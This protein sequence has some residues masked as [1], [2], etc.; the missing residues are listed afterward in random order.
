M[1]KQ[2][3]HARQ[4]RVSSAA[5]RGQASSVLQARQQ[6]PCRC[7]A[8]SASSLE[9]RLTPREQAKRRRRS[10]W[11]AIGEGRARGGHPKPPDSAARSAD[12]PTRR[13]PSG[14]SAPAKAKQPRLPKTNNSRAQET[15]TVSMAT[16]G[17]NTEPGVFRQSWVCTRVRA[18]VCAALKTC[19]PSVLRTSTNQAAR[20]PYRERAEGVGAAR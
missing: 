19:R 1:Q 9:R 8:S 11:P 7:F 3:P 18:C 2:W 16:P 6:R 12:P 17:E 4:Q 5:S 13:D 10:G 14:P 15:T 20:R